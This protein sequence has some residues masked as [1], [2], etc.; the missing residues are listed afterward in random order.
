MQIR[1]LFS[2][3]ENKS[4]EL[5]EL[6]KKNEQDKQNTTAEIQIF[7]AQVFPANVL[8]N[9]HTHTWKRGLGVGNGGNGEMWKSATQLT[10][11]AATF[12]H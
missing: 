7:P 11:D 9:K 4:K 8:F 12:G 3:C 5:R 1:K 6:R 2:K 10:S